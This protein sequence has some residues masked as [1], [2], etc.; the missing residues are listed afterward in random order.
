[1]AVQKVYWE[2][3]RLPLLDTTAIHAS[4]AVS[5]AIVPF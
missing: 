1:M 4:K 2:P 3:I 5:L